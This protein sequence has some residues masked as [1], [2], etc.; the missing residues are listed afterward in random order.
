VRVRPYAALGEIHGIPTPAGPVTEAQLL[1][2]A[3]PAAAID[4]VLAAAGPA[5]GSPQLL[6]ELRQLGGAIARIPERASAFSHRDGAFSL[7]TLGLA[8]EDAA[9]HAAGLLAALAAWSS[10]R[11]LATFG[12][13]DSPAALARVY[14][15]ET[16]RRLARL[17][18]HH[19]PHR[20]LA[21]ARGLRGTP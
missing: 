16:L 10:D 2:D 1:L 18:A 9:E 12:R 17:A 6:V 19:D 21:G 14:D 5:S 3:L 13:D 7:V 20:I 15:P 8:G 11:G 4:A